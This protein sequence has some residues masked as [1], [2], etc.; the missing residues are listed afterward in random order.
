MPK[1]NAIK[2]YSNNSY[3]HVYAR[4]SSAIFNEATKAIFLNIIKTLLSP[5]I[6]K[7]KLGRPYPNFHGQIE[8]L[9]FAIMPNHFH[10]LIYQVDKDN[11]EKFMR[12]LMTRF[13]AQYNHRHNLKGSLFQSRYLAKLIDNDAHLYH[14]S[15]YIHLNPTNWQTGRDSSLS[16]Y[17]GQKHANWINPR[18]ILD[19]FPTYDAY[20]KFLNDYD[21]KADQQFSDIEPN[22]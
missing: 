22:D 20:L 14:I 4:S 1:R 2:T 15:R 7:D 13:V 18:R 16:Y 21:P 12:S 17:S 19:L 8:L 11:L 3:Y 10:L 6:S 5:E 9:T